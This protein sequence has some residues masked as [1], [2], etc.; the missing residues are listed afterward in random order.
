MQNEAFHITLPQQ[1]TAPLV[2]ASPHSGDHIPQSML[3]CCTHT[4]DTLLQT[5]DSH[6]DVLFDAAIRHG[7]PLISAK[8][9]RIYVDLNREPTD[10][11]AE[12]FVPKLKTNAP[13]NSKAH[14]GLGVIPRVIKNQQ[15]LYEKPLPKATI[16]ERLEQ[17]Y[18][19]YHTALANL[20]QDAHKT[21][22]EVLLIDCHSMPSKNSPSLRGKDV[23]PDIVLGD[24]FGTS[25]APHYVAFIETCLKDLGFSVQRNVPYAGGT[26]TKKYGQP[27]RNIHA[28]QIEVNRALYMDEKTRAKNANFSDIQT[29]IGHFIAALTHYAKTT[30]PNAAE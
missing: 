16:K 4:K 7:A 30:L 12:M 17:A 15:A 22:K 6:M 24:L 5:Q 8:F 19:P 14:I 23:S 1:W 20:I 9:A 26:C 13:L 27:S 29:R 28:I 10:L 25:C 3:E 11:D 18:Y 2:F 21:H